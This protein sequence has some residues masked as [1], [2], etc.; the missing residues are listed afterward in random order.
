MERS[1]VKSWLVLTHS[2]NPSRGR[3]SLRPAWATELVAGQPGV[4][5]KKKGL[6]KQN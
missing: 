1:T 5:R 6:K 2:F 3:Q 4:H